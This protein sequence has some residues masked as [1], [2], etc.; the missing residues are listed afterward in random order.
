LN[1]GQE[2]SE[3]DSFPGQSL[4]VPC[5]GTPNCYRTKVQYNLDKNSL[6]SKLDHAIRKSGAETV[7]SDPGKLSIKA[8]YKIPFFSYRDDVET[9][10][11]TSGQNRSVLYIKSA[12]RTGTY[13]FGVNRRRVKRILRKI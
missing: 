9:Q 3:S 5:P 6:F 10:I 7:L 11:V 2:Y 4:P 1:T 8:V 12:S 13:D